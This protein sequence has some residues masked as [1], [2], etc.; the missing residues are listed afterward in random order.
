LPGADIYTAAGVDTG[1]GFSAIGEVGLGDVGEFGLAVNDQVRAQAAD[2]TTSQITFATANFKLGLPED[3]LFTY[4]PAIAL[5]FRKS[6]ERDF[7]NRAARIAELYLVASEHLGAHATLHIGGDMWDAADTY[8]PQTVELNQ[9][10]LAAQVRAFGGIEVEPLPRS[11]ILVEL[12]WMPEF[13]AGPDTATTNADSI[14]L[15][16]ALTWGVRY[17]VSPSINLLAGVTIPQIQ[18]ARLLDA[19]IFGRLEIT[20]RA[21]RHAF[22]LDDGQE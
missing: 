9:D 12:S 22:G 18:S 2:G 1:G 5:G 17:E 19:Q 6:F 14:K 8:N 20:T 15:N 4:Q 10:G 11:Q 16:A 21:L 7:D 13:V 3:L